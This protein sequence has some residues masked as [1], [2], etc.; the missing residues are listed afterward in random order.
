MG[1]NVLINRKPH[2]RPLL[3]G[4]LEHA[5]TKFPRVF[6]YKILQDYPYFLPC[7]VAGSLACFAAL[8]GFFFL[9]EVS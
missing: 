7:L 2:D 3:G 8:G 1:P 9:E 4:T 5:A 6:G